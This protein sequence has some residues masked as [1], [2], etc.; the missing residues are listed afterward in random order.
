MVISVPPSSLAASVIRLGFTVDRRSADQRATKRADASAQQLRLTAEALE[1]A[2]GPLT[3]PLD[4]LQALLAALADRDQ[5]GLDLA[6]A[7]NRQ[8]GWRR[9]ACV[10]PCS[11]DLSMAI[12]REQEADG[13]ALQDHAVVSGTRLIAGQQSAGS[14]GKN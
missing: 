3:S 8:A 7:L 14:D 4:A 13:R 2:R 10:V 12:A 11:S 6:A 1:P 5:L 9:Y